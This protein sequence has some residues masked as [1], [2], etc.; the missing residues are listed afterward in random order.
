MIAHESELKLLPR[1]E[2]ARAGTCKRTGGM[3]SCKVPEV[4]ESP[5]DVGLQEARRGRCELA[6]A[7]NGLEEVRAPSD[8]LQRRPHRVWLVCQASRPRHMGQCIPGGVCPLQRQW[9]SGSVRPPRGAYD[10]SR[11][12]GR[13]FSR[14]SPSRNAGLGRSSPYEVRG[15]IPE[16]KRLPP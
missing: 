9:L 12:S 2:M 10:A 4:P 3:D 6:G 7:G 8:S 5:G 15:W 11:A 14:R 1:M 13:P 16:L